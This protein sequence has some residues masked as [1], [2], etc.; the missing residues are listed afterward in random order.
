MQKN[1]FL[2]GD[3]TSHSL[4]EGLMGFL[5]DKYHI[6]D[7]GISSDASDDYIDITKKLTSTLLEGG[8]GILICGSGLGVSIA[9][10]RSSHIR[11]TLCR[12]SEDAR[13]GRRQNDANVLC[14]GSKFTT[15]YA[16]KMIVDTFLNTPF[17]H[18]NHLS[19]MEK[20]KFQDN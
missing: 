8:V 18:Q 4:R 13:L 9:A 14:L 6:I 7:L 11:A 12:V 15:L 10:N 2:A 17:K 20:L 5:H 3:H 16:A 1:I 19:S